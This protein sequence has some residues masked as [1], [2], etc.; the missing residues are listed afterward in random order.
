M[1][2]LCPMCRTLMEDRNRLHCRNGC[3]QP[4]FVDRLIELVREAS[5]WKEHDRPSRICCDSVY[6]KP[7]RAICWFGAA[8]E[9]SK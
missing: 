6:G 2:V 8:L 1:S 3:I 5:E 4:E 9:Q 7:H